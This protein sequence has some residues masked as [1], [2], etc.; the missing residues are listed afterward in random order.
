[1]V[2]WLMVRDILG[3]GDPAGSNIYFYTD[4]IDTG[5]IRMGPLWDFDMAFEM[6]ESWSLQHDVGFLPFEYAWQSADF[7]KKYTAKWVSMAPTIEKELFDALDGLAASEGKAIERSRT[8]NSNIW[9]DPKTLSSEIEAEKAFF[10]KQLAW[11][12]AQLSP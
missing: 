9:G 8:R 7:R 5:L 4:N 6:S 10:T 12:N 1:M 3:H 2:N 11:I